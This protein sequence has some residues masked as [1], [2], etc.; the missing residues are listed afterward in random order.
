MRTRKPKQANS[1]DPRESRIAELNHALR[2][3]RKELECLYAISRLVE[4]HDAL[5]DILRGLVS[6]LPVAWQYPKACHVRLTLRGRQHVSR[7]FR[8]SPC[9]LQERLIV[10]GEHVGSIEVFY[11]IATGQEE[12]PLLFLPEEKKLLTAIAQRTSR[13]IARC[14]TE[15]QLSAEHAA[16]QETNTALRAILSRFEEDKNQFQQEL[17][18]NIQRVLSPLIAALEDRAT[19]SARQYV[20]CLRQNLE[21]LVSPFSQTA[22]AR[23]RSL[24]PGEIEVCE[25]IRTGHKTKEIAQCRNVSV[26]TVKKQREQIR[27][28]LHL[29]HTQGNLATHLELRTVS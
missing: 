13:I 3:R 29:S 26:A 18:N 28:K 15:Q 25:L 21:E 24:S 10:K 6:L 23:Y 11:S 12:P 2:E 1:A 9:F 17:A 4:T 20:V 14:W 19:E 5:D 16:L 27:R 22:L 7:R 8:P